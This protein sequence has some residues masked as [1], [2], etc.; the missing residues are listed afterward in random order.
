M[1]RTGNAVSVIL[2]TII[3]A[4]VIGAVTLI[5]AFVNN[6]AKNFYVQYGDEKISYKT[7]NIE[8]P[9]DAYSLFY[10]KNVFGL[11]DKTEKAKN[12][13]VQ[14]VFNENNMK[15]C[16]MTEFAVD[17]KALEFY[18]IDFTDYFDIKLYDGYFTVY[19]PFALTLGEL[20][21]VVYP[22]STVTG[23]TDIDLYE[24]DR[25]SIVVYSEEEQAT[26]TINFR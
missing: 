24:K 22:N 26:V 18:R 6:G 7:E 3:F 10:C 13:T 9:K 11:T 16:D 19:L 2:Y 12:F 5:I 8:L 1:K 23:F 20:L 25:L 21:S 17:G 14:I 15:D 4:V